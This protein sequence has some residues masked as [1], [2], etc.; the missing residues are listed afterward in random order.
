METWFWTLVRFLSILTMAGNGFLIVLVRSKGQL[1]TKTNTLLIV[2]LA[3]V[4]FCVGM[5][6]VPSRF[7]CGMANKRISNDTASLI[8]IYVG[9]LLVYASGSNLFSLALERYITV[10]KPSKYLTFM[11]SRRVI[12][13]VLT[14]GEF[15]SFS[16]RL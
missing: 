16:S 10:A 5:I 6:V 1:R 12:H 4:D 11:T 9:V 7:L 15:L 13:M 3:V 8:G 2:S 14:S